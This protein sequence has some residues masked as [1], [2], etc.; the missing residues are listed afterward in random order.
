MCTGIAQRRAGDGVGIFHGA[1]VNKVW[2]E[3]VVAEQVRPSYQKDFGSLN[4]LLIRKKICVTG[5]ILSPSKKQRLHYL[6]ASEQ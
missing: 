3:K 5:V 1:E 2:L 6:S 4:P